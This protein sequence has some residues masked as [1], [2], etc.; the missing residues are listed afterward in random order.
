MRHLARGVPL[1]AA[2]RALLGPGRVVRIDEDFS[3][4]PTP[5]PDEPLELWCA[6]RALYW[7]THPDWVGFDEGAAF[8]GGPLTVWLGQSP[9]DRLPASWWCAEALRRGVADEVS[10]V[11]IAAPNLGSFPAGWLATLLPGQPIDRA[12]VEGLADLWRAWCAPEPTALVVLS[13]GAPDDPQTQAATRLLDRYPDQTTG[14]GSHDRRLLAHAHGSSLARA[15]GQVL[16]E[17]WDLRDCVGDRWLFA[18]AKALADPRL[19]RPL[20]TLAPRDDQGRISSF[21]AELTPDGLAVL[22]GRAHAIELNGPGF[23]EP[24]G[25]VRFDVP[26][27]PVWLRTPDGV[28][29]A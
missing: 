24:I 20:L 3:V 23:L 26:G 25:G 17:N 22:E 28:I 13:Q 10:V 16:G 5:K 27:G 18:R 19:R 21:S 9:A 11:D 1:A 14:L 29:R 15:I 7:Q 6:R 4:G 2:L 8:S 12:D